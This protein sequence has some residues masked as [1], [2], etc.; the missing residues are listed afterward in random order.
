LLRRERMW[1]L[2]HETPSSCMKWHQIDG[3]KEYNSR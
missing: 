3:K 2:V 1:P